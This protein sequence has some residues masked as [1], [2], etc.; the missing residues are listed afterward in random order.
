MT[1]LP[2]PAS[3]STACTCTISDPWNKCDRFGDLKII[4]VVIYYHR[5]REHVRD[6][7]H[8]YVRD[9]EHVRG[10]E[11]D[12]HR[13]RDLDYVRDRDPNHLRDRDLLRDRNR[14]MFVSVIVNVIV[15]VIAVAIDIVNVIDIVFITLIKSHHQTRF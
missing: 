3:P 2:T 1:A 8:H 10:P 5:D 6:R 9:R 14:V 11:Q 12:L 13:D 15:F 7:Y 4:I